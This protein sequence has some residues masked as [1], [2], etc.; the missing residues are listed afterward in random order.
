[1][2]LEGTS[3]EQVEAQL[4]RILSTDGFRRSPSLSR[5]LKYLVAQSLAGNDRIKEYQLG[6]DVFDRNQD[7][8]PKD[9]TIVRVQM[10]N[11]RARLDEY[12]ADPLSVDRVR[13]VVPKGAYVLR[14]E[15]VE[16]D[17]NAS[18]AREGLVGGERA[19]LQANSPTRPRRRLLIAAAIL[20]AFAGV[21]V[22]LTWRNRSPANPPSIVVIPFVNLSADPDSEYFSAGLTEELIDALAHV[23]GLR[24]LAR[25]ASMRLKDKDTDLARLRDSGVGSV[26]EGSVRKSGN[27]VR[28]AVRLIEAATGKHLWSHE[29]DTEV[30]DAIATEQVIAASVAGT[31]RLQLAGGTSPAAARTPNPEAYEL[32]LKGLYN[33][34][35]IDPA[36]A[37]KGID[38]LERSIAIDDQ[39]APA[40]VAL[41]GCYG[42][43]AILH[44]IPPANAFAKV[45]ENA[46]KALALD[47]S[48]AEAHTLLAGMYAWED[49]NWGRAELEY[50]KSA[51]LG[52]QNMIA[53]QYYASF[54]GSLGKAAE[55][56]AQMQEALKLDQF[57]SLLQ[58]GEAQLMYWR[59]ESKAAETLLKKIARQDPD[60]ALT[61][62]LLAEIE[63]TLGNDAEAEAAVRRRLGRH[64]SDA[65][66]IGQLG[67]ALAKAGKRQEARGILDQLQALPPKEVPP[68]AHAFVYQGLGDYDQAIEELWKACDARAIRPTWL[69]ES[70]FYQPLRK[71]PRFRELMR[72]VNLEP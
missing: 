37:M 62:R 57:D 55:A 32:Y 23:R 63:W 56:E 68:Q 70:A 36:S 35:Q 48:L 19:E 45:R 3:A 9:D 2:D 20:V 46:Q 22:W 47:D 13:F 25:T 69:R 21:L 53:H 39:F 38:F 10:R 58:W 28:I 50:R 71:R 5:L 24:V 4:D 49:W 6:V 41:A 29:Y 72:H 54:L 26:V 44:A 15:P 17:S 59:G 27:R 33:W 16:N 8:D 7:F 40:Y 65:V 11:L 14:F 51:Q 60:F 30:Q 34:H 31:L 43:Q 18:S 66:A 64:P 52:A 12:A 1:M 42:V 61:E 67:Y